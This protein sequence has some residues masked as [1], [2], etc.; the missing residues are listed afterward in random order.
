M[1]KI[2]LL[3]ICASLSIS[4]AGCNNS[5]NSSEKNTEVISSTENSAVSKAEE[6]TSKEEK[7]SA[8]S[9]SREITQSGN[10]KVVFNEEPF[11]A[12][13]KYAATDEG[14]YLKNENVSEEF[15]HISY[16]D[17][18]S[19]QEIVLC[20][21]SACKHDN[22]KC[23]AVL[24]YDE[25]FPDPTSQYFF[26]Y[27]EYLYILNAESDIE[28]TFT[29]GTD[30]TA[31]DVE[32]PV[33]THKNSLYRMNLDG[34]NREKLF[35]F[36]EGNAVEGFVVGDG[37]NLWF[38]T[39]T[40]Y[41]YKDDKGRTYNTSKNRALMKYSLKE[42]S[43]TERI[44]LDE[45]NNVKLRFEGVYK[46]KFIFSG[47]AYPDGKSAEDY[48]DILS[49]K[50]TME[51]QIKNMDEFTE[52]HN[53][54]EYVLFT[55]NRDN[56][57]INEIFRAKY[58]DVDNSVSIDSVLAYLSKTDDTV[59]FLDLETGETRDVSAPEGYYFAG[60][61]GGKKYY[62]RKYD[63]KTDTAPYFDDGN[64]GVIKNDWWQFQNN[65]IF[66]NDKFAF[67]NTGRTGEEQPDGNLKNPHDAYVLI[68]IDDLQNG[69]ENI[70]PIK[71]LEDKP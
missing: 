9:D 68:P 33:E 24:S 22:E 21:D 31:P 62:R 64:G 16:I 51:E 7:I 66:A 30:F 35:N 34:T 55:L 8:E 47:T 20:A 46:N 32:T 53:K 52:F 27:G 10:L 23:T 49:P 58:T 69:R 5:T 17:F 4:L 44:P 38:I 40:P 12:Q 48:L 18:E 14:V 41:V 11:F 3:I 37:D 1:K 2:A 43:F 61:I 67:V 26:V 39:K 19:E 57:S 50:G 56:K 65:I 54:C 71:R 70:V 42:R 36:D 28:K 63:G 45:V 59:F 15:D 13:Q 60:F 25:F 29:A 6:N